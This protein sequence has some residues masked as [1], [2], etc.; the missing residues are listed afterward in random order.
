MALCILQTQQIRRESMRIYLSINSVPELD[1]YPKLQKRML[2]RR[3]LKE[4]RSNK[5]V[6]LGCIL[7]IIGIIIPDVIFPEFDSIWL[8]ML[9]ALTFGIVI[10]Y[11]SGHIIVAA[12]RPT[13]ARYR[14]ELEQATA[15]NDHDYFVPHA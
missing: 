3:A 2:W 14:R 15:Q 8:T 11:I 9:L 12:I 13:L 7:L 10:G 6:W 5:I 1:G 4:N